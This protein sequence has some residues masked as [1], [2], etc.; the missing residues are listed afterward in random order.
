MKI[1]YVG[2]AD[3]I[4][5]YVGDKPF[6]TTDDFADDHGWVVAAH[7]E[8]VDVPEWVA[9]GI[10]ATDEHPGYS[11]KLD[12]PDWEHPKRSRKSEPEPTPEEATK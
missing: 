2:P 1:Q 3:A 10:P 7:G 9:V 5:F 4:E 8:T 6:E 11:G 12:Q